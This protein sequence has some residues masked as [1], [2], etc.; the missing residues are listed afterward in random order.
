MG[1]LRPKTVSWGY[2]IWKG[3]SRLTGL[4]CRARWWVVRGLKS[5][6]RLSH[7]EQIN[8]LSAQVLTP[9]RTFPISAKVPHVFFLTVESHVLPLL[10]AIR[11][12][13]FFVEVSSNTPCRIRNRRPSLIETTPWKSR[14]V[15]G[16]SVDTVALSLCAHHPP[17]R[18]IA[19][20]SGYRPYLISQSAWQNHQ[21]CFALGRDAPPWCLCIPNR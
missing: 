20:E 17:I 1:C 14:A 6:I 19:A 9:T 11:H 4:N 12:T 15:I 21:G 3:F 5:S 8:T 7:S 18:K 10:V 13:V 16:F 2:K